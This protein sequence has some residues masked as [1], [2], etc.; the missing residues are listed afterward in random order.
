M[1]HEILRSEA[2]DASFLIDN[3]AEKNNRHHH[4]I[5]NGFTVYNGT[6][7]GFNG[8]CG[9]LLV[10]GYLLLIVFSHVTG[11]KTWRAKHP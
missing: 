10:I 6:C 1:T 4:K 11:S 9:S 8:P 3:P 7:I 5:C 2:R